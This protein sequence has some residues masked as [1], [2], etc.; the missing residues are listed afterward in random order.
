MP[1]CRR[2]ARCWLRRGAPGL[3][4]GSEDGRPGDGAPSARGEARGAPPPRSQR[5]S[6]L[7]GESGE[8]RDR[9]ARAAQ[10]GLRSSHR[11][12]AATKGSGDYQMC[13]SRPDRD[14]CALQGSEDRHIRLPSSRPRPNEVCAGRQ[15]CSVHPGRQRSFRLATLS[16]RDSAYQGSPFAPIVIPTGSGRF[17]L[18]SIGL[19]ASVITPSGFIRAMLPRRF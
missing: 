15:A 14:F 9:E 7:A 4:A 18:K 6:R 2:E 13:C 12:L 11:T 19:V 8:G 1:G 17:L 16:T 10:I 3:G 5:R